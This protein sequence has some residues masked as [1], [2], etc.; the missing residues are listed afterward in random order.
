MF[1]KQYYRWATR[2]RGRRQIRLQTCNVTGRSL[3]E[4]EHQTDKSTNL[5]YVGVNVRDQTSVGLGET[6]GIHLRLCR[7]QAL[8]IVLEW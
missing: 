3:G 8:G 1:G 5:R 6:L 4:K 2:A 7:E